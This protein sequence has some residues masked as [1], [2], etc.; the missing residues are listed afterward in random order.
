MPS[1]SLCVSLAGEEKLAFE[2]YSDKSLKE[3]QNRK[4]HQA[5]ANQYI[6]SAHTDAEREQQ[7]EHDFLLQFENEVDI[8]LEPAS[9]LER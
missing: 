9:G 3:Y 7:R 5:L 8:G 6:R 4:Q 2:H 1:S